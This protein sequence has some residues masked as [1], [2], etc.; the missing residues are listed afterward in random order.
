[1][2]VLVSHRK[3]SHRPL[4]FRF[5]HVLPIGDSG[6]RLGDSLSTL[7]KVHHDNDSKPYPIAVH[8]HRAK[9]IEP[10]RRSCADRD[11]RHG[12]VFERLRTR[13]RQEWGGRVR[14]HWASS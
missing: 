3:H 4:S 6:Q 2:T 9:I 14:R 11:I 10:Y 13:S 1:M 7:D 12:R 5:G 8:D